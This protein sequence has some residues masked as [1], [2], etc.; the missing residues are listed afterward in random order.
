MTGRG[1]VAAILFGSALTFVAFSAAAQDVLIRNATVH[2]AGPQGTLAN[3]DV[4]IAGGKVRAV[5]VG[6]LAPAGAQV[7]DAQG[8][9]LSPTLFGGITEIGLEEVSG[10]KSTV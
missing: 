2:T 4:L 6:L 10:E 7:I 3:A 5:G 1:A 9:P 8:R